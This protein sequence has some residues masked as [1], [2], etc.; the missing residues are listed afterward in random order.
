MGFG[1]IGGGGNNFT[2]PDYSLSPITYPRYFNGWEVKEIS[3]FYLIPAYNNAN[4]FLGVPPP[5]SLAVPI[6]ISVSSYDEVSN[7]WVYNQDWVID[8]RP[9]DAFLRLNNSTSIPIW[10]AGT[11]KYFFGTLKLIGYGGIKNTN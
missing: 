4:I 2:L 9:T 3:F 5:K 1:S 11:L 8:T 10:V 7:R 6:E